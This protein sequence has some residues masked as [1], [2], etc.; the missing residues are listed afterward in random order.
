MKKEGLT[1]KANRNN[2]HD[3]SANTHKDREQTIRMCV[4]TFFNI[5]GKMPRLSDMAEW[6]G[7]EYIDDIKAIFG[8]SSSG[9]CYVAA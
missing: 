9:L 1:V 6:L 4:Q 3:F 2:R 5:Y 7:Q 8:M